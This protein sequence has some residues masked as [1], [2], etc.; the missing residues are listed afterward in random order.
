MEVKLDD[1]RAQKRM[2]KQLAKDRLRGRVVLTADRARVQQS[3]EN[4][5]YSRWAKGP[6]RHLADASR[7]AFRL[8]PDYAQRIEWMREHLKGG[9]GARKEE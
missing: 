7:A 9:R 1:K 3:L 6:G 2:Q 5:A 4:M 8:L